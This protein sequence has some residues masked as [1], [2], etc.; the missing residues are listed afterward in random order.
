MSPPDGRLRPTVA[1]ALISAALLAGCGDA[2][3]EHA[4][5][6]ERRSGYRGVTLEEPVA[7]PD[8]TL[9]DT[10]GNRYDFRR[11]TRGK[12]TL[13]FFGYTHCPDVCPA[14]MDILG[15]AYADLPPSVTQELEVVFVT[16]D[17]AR[18][19][20]RRMR[21]WLDRFGGSF[22]G[23]R[24]RKSK[25]D[26]IQ[27]ALGLQAGTIRRSGMTARVADGYAVNHTSAV[28]AFPP[29]GPARL[30]Y[31]FGTRQRDWAHDL[32]RLVERAGIP[33]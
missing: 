13:L 3:G 5:E 18:D 2:P 20:R 16:A 28:L 19:T 26:S 4:G 12:V 33:E 10:E 21:R 22:V 6:R 24:G 14:Q 1:T 32:P 9:T 31:P 30:A 27:R 29:D 8:F 11:D 25:V 23:L 17:P 7:R 15:S